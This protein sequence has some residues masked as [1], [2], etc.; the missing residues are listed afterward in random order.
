MCF[1]PH[2]IRGDRLRRL[3]VRDIAGPIGH[4]HAHVNLGA[5]TGRHRPTIAAVIAKASSDRQPRPIGTDAVIEVNRF[6]L[7]A[8][9][10]GDPSDDECAILR[11]DAGDLS[12]GFAGVHFDPPIGSFP[13][14][15]RSAGRTGAIAHD[16]G[17]SVEAVAGNSERNQERIARSVAAKNQQAADEGRGAAVSLERPSLR[18]V[19]P[20]GQRRP[21]GDAGHG[22]A[23]GVDLGGRGHRARGARDPLGIDRVV[24]SSDPLRGG[25]GGAQDRA[26]GHAGRAPV[27]ALPDR[28]APRA[29][30]LPLAIC[31]RRVGGAAQVGA[32]RSAARGRPAH[33]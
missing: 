31:D 19:A 14:S 5:K 7:E 16:Q 23:G 12:D 1:R 20:Q 10:G 13:R 24:F 6:R 17:Q 29:L 26:A 8:V 11:A 2:G 22:R 30:A 25:G 9:I 33:R 21:A 27:A 28:G 3:A 32:G 4:F 15:G 18:R